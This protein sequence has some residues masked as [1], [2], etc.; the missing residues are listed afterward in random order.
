M[1]GSLLALLLV[2]LAGCGIMPYRRADLSSQAVVLQTPLTQQDEM[3]DC[4]LAAISALCGYYHV[5]IPASERAQLAQL[6]S[7]KEGL[8]GTELVAALER[9][10]ME[11]YLF[12]GTLKDGPTSLEHNIVAH[13]PMLVMT[14]IAGNHHYG[15]VVGIDPNDGSVVIVD[16]ALGRIVMPAADFERRWA[17]T[18]HFT[19]LAMPAQ[20]KVAGNTEH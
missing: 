20:P 8:S 9:C 15:L 10:G 3:Y 19:M 18:K 1:R 17:L 2:A 7:S 11:V 14:E 12:E 5:E 4:G 16:P 6:A 13:R